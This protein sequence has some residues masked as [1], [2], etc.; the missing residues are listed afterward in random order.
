M[1]ILFKNNLKRIRDDF[2]LEKNHNFKINKII[3]GKDYNS[4]YKNENKK[5]GNSCEN[6]KKKKMIFSIKSK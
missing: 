3:Q 2:S 4:K 6:N 5:I 1:E